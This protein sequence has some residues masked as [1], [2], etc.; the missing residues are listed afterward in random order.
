V[1]EVVD[2]LLRRAVDDERDGLGELLRRATVQGGELLPFELEGDE[3][4]A[5]LRP[6]AGVAVAADLGDLRVLEDR[7]IEV[8]GLLRLRVE[9]EERCD[10]LHVF[11]SFFYMSERG[12]VSPHARS[13]PGQSAMSQ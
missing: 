10:L 6:R 11:F 4:D 2:L 8:R 3:H 13:N 9:P 12:R 5:P 1:P 7:Y